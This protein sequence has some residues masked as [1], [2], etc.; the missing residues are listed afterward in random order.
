MDA[1]RLGPAHGPRVIGQEAFDRE[2]KKFTEGAHKFGPRVRG[3]SPS[4]APQPGAVVKHGEKIGG[5]PDTPD[6]LPLDQLQKALTENPSFF[7]GLYEA[8]LS[9][10]DGARPKALALFRTVE[11]QQQRRT[12]VIEEIDSL[13]ASKQPEVSGPTTDEPKPETDESSE[14]ETE[15]EEVEVDELS[16]AE[17]EAKFAELGGDPTTIKAT[18]RGG[19]TVREDILKAVKK[20]LKAQG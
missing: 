2:Q 8:E 19:R 13:L 16:K 4:T 11:M 5:T 1:Q 18:G 14:P 9:R 17:L 12:D 10:P 20:L 15:T 6:V 7:D 3:S